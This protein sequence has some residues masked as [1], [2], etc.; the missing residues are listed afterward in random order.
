MV[1]LDNL[2]TAMAAI[3]AEIN[4]YLKKEDASSIYMTK[5]SANKS[6]A[7]KSSVTDVGYFSESQD[8]LTSIGKLRFPYFSRANRTLGTVEYNPRQSNLG[9]LGVAGASNISFVFNL[10]GENNE[11]IISVGNEIEGLKP[12][13][14]I[15]GTF[16]K[17]DSELNNIKKVALSNAQDEYSTPTKNQG[18][19]HYNI[20]VTNLFD[21]G[22]KLSFKLSASN[23]PNSPRLQG[24]AY[25]NSGELY[26]FISDKISSDSTLNIP[27]T[28]TRIDGRYEKLPNPNPIHI[29][30]Y[31]KDNSTVDSEIVYDGTG[32]KYLYLY[33]QTLNVKL[34]Q[35]E[36]LYYS[37]VEY[38][39]IRRAQG[40][41]SRQVIFS[42]FS[43]NGLFY[44]LPLVYTGT[45][46]GKDTCMFSGLVNKSDYYA[47]FMIFK[48]NT[49]S[50]TDKPQ[51]AI[52]T[53]TVPV[54]KDGSIVID[55]STTDSTKKF[56]ITVDDN[57]AL[58]LINI[59]N[60]SEVW[61]GGTYSKPAGG[62]P[63][64]D[65]AA[66]VQ[67]SLGKADTALQEH[68]SLA[69]YATEDWVTGK[70]YLTLETLPKYGG[71]TE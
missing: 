6:F 29:V 36:N 65:L 57:G 31:A 20:I 24:M 19:M 59:E 32:E 18:T 23:N 14:S 35:R 55:S 60:S 10:P 26:Y 28:I 68:Q 38:F 4:S 45:D 43:Y 41:D 8:A 66:A 67:T 27:F 42:T 46:N 44:N 63:K 51:G 25:G 33:N 71:E 17:T 61:N 2:K 48:G 70:G 21:S 40:F 58:S 52:E 69:G 9:D 12:G 13:D 39:K 54:L 62:I 37:D 30:S 50:T 34:I 5:D 56:K 53:Y 11:D 64:A 3:K 49:D 7:T 16:A 47:T 15:S 1:S 22:T